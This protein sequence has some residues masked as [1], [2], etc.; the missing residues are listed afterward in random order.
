MIK[1]IILLAVFLGF[2]S[3]VYAGNCGFCN[4]TGQ[5]TCGGTSFTDQVCGGTSFTTQ[6]CGSTDLTDYYY[7]SNSACYNYSHNP[8]SVYGKTC[9][10]C[11]SS[12]TD[13]GYRKCNV[14]GYEDWTAPIMTSCEKITGYKCNS[15]GTVYD[16]KPSAC[17]HV[18]GYKCDSCGYI[19]SSKPASCSQKKTCSHC[20]GTGLDN[21]APASPSNFTVTE[22][23]NGTVKLSWTA[24]SENDVVGYFVYISQTDNIDPDN[25]NTY[26]NWHYETDTSDEW[27]GLTN[28]VKYYFAVTA[29]DNASPYNESNTSKISTVTYTHG[30]RPQVW[31]VPSTD[32]KYKR[33]NGTFGEIHPETVRDH[34]HEGIDIDTYGLPDAIA[35]LDGIVDYIAS[36][37]GKNNYVLV[38]HKDSSGDFERRKTRYLHIDTYTLISVG[39]PVSKGT[40]LGKIRSDAGHLHFEMWYQDGTSD[41]RVNPLKNNAGNWSLQSLAP[42]DEGDPVINSVFLQP[43]TTSDKIKFESSTG[44]IEYKDDA[45]PT[46][47]KHC[48]IHFTGDNVYNKNTDKICVSGKI[49]PIINTVDSKINAETASQG[50]GLTVY[51]SSYSIDGENKYIVE[52]DR[53]LHT[54]RKEFNQIFH[55]SAPCVTQTC[56]ND[57]YIELYSPDTTYLYPHKLISGQRSNGI[58]DTSSYSEGEHKLTFYSEDASGRNVTEEVK[59]I[60]DNEIPRVKSKSP[61]LVTDISVVEPIWFEFSEQMEKLTVESYGKVSVTVRD[62]TDGTE[63]PVNGTVIYD[64]TTHRVE[65]KPDSNYLLYGKKYKVTLSSMILDLAGN[66]LDDDDFDFFSNSNG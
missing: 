43:K 19:Y 50:A 60:I 61:A 62:K 18:T 31:P 33:I 25:P 34:F 56:G 54:N 45:D 8:S 12:Y 23:K 6:Y 59:I 55:T 1:R 14:C 32:S 39:D 2:Y 44:G 58:L 47:P 3:F 9:P 49:L 64:T 41:Y 57:D 21:T 22:A 29:T 48:Q 10:L 38:K 42:A 40:I 13:W 30:Y 7:C 17:T 52:F 16:T 66:N 24:N 53:I 5:V 65:F 63:S 4:G 51:K 37:K 28:G 15:C 26:T 11:G 36:D 20:G 27:T 35:V 46:K